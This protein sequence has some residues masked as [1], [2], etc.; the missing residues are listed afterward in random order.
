MFLFFASALAGSTSLELDLDGDGKKE[1]VRYDA[2]AGIVRI[3]PGKVVCE[4]DPCEV[5][6]HD[7]SS[8]DKRREVV[9][10]A[11]GPRDD[12]ACS[13]HTVVN[14]A[15]KTFALRRDGPPPK[16]T[17]SGNGLVLVHEAYRHRL[18]DRVEKYRA[19]GLTL[20]EVKQPIYTSAKAA[21]LPVDRTFPLL[22][23][24]KGNQVVANTRPHSTIQILGEHGDH[25]GWLLVR[26]SSGISGWVE[27]TR[28]EAASDRYMMIMGAG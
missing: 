10:C 24:P 21:S 9:V 5:E 25:T 6:A 28:L 26:L 3:G 1:A 18:I 15:V 16:I 11:F 14:G 4:G 12:T 23:A 8:A 22:Y 20:T 19:E 13:L 2:A 27:Q 17:T 7:V